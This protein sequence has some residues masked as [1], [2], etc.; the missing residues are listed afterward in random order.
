MA[1]VLAFAVDIT[2]RKLAEEALQ[3]SEDKYRKLAENIPGMVFQF[4]LHKDSSF[5]LPYVNERITQYVGISP[6]AAMAEPSLLFNPIH[7]DDQEMFQQAISDSAR[8]LR[9]FSVEHRL[10]D[11]NRK[12]RWFRVESMP[13]QLF[14]GDILWNGVSIDI[15]KRKRTEA[16]LAASEQQR[17]LRGS[18]NPGCL[19]EA[20]PDPAPF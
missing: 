2:E 8:T 11:S 10:I 17:I 16:S 5:S 3:A 14:N 15:T 19:A 20:A 12:L 1:G 18:Q 13:Q 6:E 9:R 7:S 4:I